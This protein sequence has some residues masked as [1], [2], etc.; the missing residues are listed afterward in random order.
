MESLDNER[1]IIAFSSIQKMIE[2]RNI[3]VNNNLIKYIQQAEDY[4]DE[5][6]V[7][8]R[9]V[10]E[11]ENYNFKIDDLRQVL[12]FNGYSFEGDKIKQR[13]ELEK[14]IERFRDYSTI[15]KKME[16]NPKSIFS[17]NSKLKK[18]YDI[19]KR[20]NNFYERKMD[21]K[22]LENNT[23]FWRLKFQTYYFAYSF[24]HWNSIKCCR[25]WDY[26]VV[27]RYYNVLSFL[28]IFF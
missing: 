28:H 5:I 9:S 4:F 11:E 13:E 1:K 25:I 27:V 21:E 12:E 22:Y 24:V 10:L 26:F 7:C 2:K 23:K 16:D 14:V 3:P 18:I 20:L 17:D 6:I 15:F 19:S 8:A